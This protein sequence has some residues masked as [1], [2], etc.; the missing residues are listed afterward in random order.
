MAKK[1]D[2]PTKIT[3]PYKD[4]LDAFMRTAPPQPKKMGK[5]VALKLEKLKKRLAKKAAEEKLLEEE[6]ALKI[7]RNLPKL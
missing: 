3:V 4:A 6:A 7:T 5:E 2:P 1:K